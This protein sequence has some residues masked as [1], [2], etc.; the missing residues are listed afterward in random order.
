MNTEDIKTLKQLFPPDAG[1]KWGVYLQR[2]LDAGIVTDTEG[3]WLQDKYGFWAME[4]KVE[5]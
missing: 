5:P 3:G 1:E 2:A 4:K